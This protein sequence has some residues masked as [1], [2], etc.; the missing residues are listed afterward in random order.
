MLPRK[1]GLTVLYG[2]EVVVKEEVTSWGWF[3]NYSECGS[4]FVELN[5]AGFDPHPCD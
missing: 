2:F 1:G 3:F 5:K 4:V